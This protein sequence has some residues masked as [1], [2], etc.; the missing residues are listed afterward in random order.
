MEEYRFRQGGPEDVES[1]IGLVDR[2]MAWMDR[3]GIDQW[4]NSHYHERYPREYYRER[5]AR[6]ELYVL[7]RLGDGEAVAA[8]VLF[9][10]DAR[11][12]ERPESAFYIHHLASSE[13]VKGAGAEFV[14]RAAEYARSRGKQFLRLDSKIGNE[15]LERWYNSLGFKAVGE[16]VD[17]Y[18][19]G[20]LR[21]L[22]LVTS[23]RGVS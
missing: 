3:V 1:L 10:R 22:E 19:E 23:R 18:Y 17:L 20:V 13:D 4:N 7:E 12:G 21:E 11:W 2:R 9:E 16:C 5:A 15:A 6:G 14:R 8:A